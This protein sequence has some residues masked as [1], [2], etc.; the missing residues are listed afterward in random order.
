MPMKRDLTKIPPRYR[1]EHDEVPVPDW[2]SA[3]VFLALFACL[4][5][6]WRWVFG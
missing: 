5:V 3:L 1:W 2:K 4:A 6:F